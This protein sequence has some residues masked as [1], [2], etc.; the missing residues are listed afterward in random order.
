MIAG[1]K[2]QLLD[3]SSGFLEAVDLSRAELPVGRFV[4]IRRAVGRVWQVRPVRATVACQ[5]GRGLMVWRRIT[6]LL[7]LRRRRGRSLHGRHRS[8]WV[9]RCHPPR[10]PRP[11]LRSG[12]H[13]C[14]DIR[15][16]MSGFG[17][18]CR[19]R[20]GL[21][22]RRR[23][24]ILEYRGSRSQKGPGLPA[25]LKVLRSICALRFRTMLSDSVRECKLR[26]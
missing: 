13:K 11:V 18:C 1:R 17:S 14:S 24:A 5:P 2:R 6:P 22:R 8:R 16:R 23:C 20:Y 15:R 21:V 4:P 10:C 3:F 19:G 9:C 25:G 26:H 7:P 12:R